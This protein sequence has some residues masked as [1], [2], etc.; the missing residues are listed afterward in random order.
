MITIDNRCI[1]LIEPSEGLFLNAYHD[2]IDPIGVDT[3]GYGTIQYPPT[4][5]GGKKVK[6]GDP[7]I[8]KQQAIDFLMWEVREQTKVIDPLL[9]DDLTVN[10]FNALTSFTYNEGCTRFKTSTL[11]SKVNAN[12]NDPTIRDEFMKWV[13]AEGKVQRGLVIRRKAEADLYFTK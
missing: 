7:A 4:Y 11:R 8:T 1:E 3:I 9:R 6:V 5:L 2:S 10:Q 12:P 13:Y